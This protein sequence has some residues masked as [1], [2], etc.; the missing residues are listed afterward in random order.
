MPY[1]FEIASLLA[2]PADEV[3]AH[4]TTMAGV[5]REL[6]PLARM[7]YPPGLDRLDAQRL[8]IG[9]R[10]FRSWILLLGVVPVDYDDLSFEAVGPGRFLERSRM[11]T[12]HEWR[13]ERLVRATPHGC[14]ITDRVGFTPR[15]RWLGPAFLVVFRAAFRRRHRN[16]RRLFGA[17]TA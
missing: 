2:A 3:W 5:N 17:D 4:A 9:V 12:Q 16:L 7:T 15:L 1:A 10:V 13:H 14:E 6:W 8:P 11:L